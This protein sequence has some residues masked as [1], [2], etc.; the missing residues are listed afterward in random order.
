MAASHANEDDLMDMLNAVTPDKSDPDA[1]RFATID[2]KPTRSNATYG[3]TVYDANGKPNGSLLSISVP[4]FPYTAIV[5]SDTSRYNAIMVA[6]EDTSRRVTAIHKAIHDAVRAGK[7]QAE[8]EIN[9]N[10]YNARKDLY[11]AV[12]CDLQSCGY[13]WSVYEKGNMFYIPASGMSPSSGSK[14]ITV[15]IITFGCPSEPYKSLV[16]V[17]DALRGLGVNVITVVGHPAIFKRVTF[18][19]GLDPDTNV[20]G[21]R[22]APSMPVIGS[23]HSV[24]DLIGPVTKDLCI[25]LKSSAAFGLYIV[26]FDNETEDMQRIML[27]PRTK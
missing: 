24:K 10:E 7:Q 13:G 2:P 25:M 16:E 17:E 27:T 23:N 22:P 14:T 19:V 3:V 15:I 12:K 8:F 18:V 6:A 26:A 11:D 5:G 1:G 9:T 20:I 4:A 21:I